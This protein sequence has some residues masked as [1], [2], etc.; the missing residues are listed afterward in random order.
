MQNDGPAYEQLAKE[1]ADRLSA[2]FGMATE[3]CDHKVTLPGRATTNE[4]DVLWVGTIGGERHRVLIECK[5]YGRALEQGKVHLF[6]SVIDDV[7]ADGIPTTGVYVTRAGYQRGAKDIAKTYDVVL[8]ELRTPTDLDLANRVLRIDYEIEM[9]TVSFKGVEFTWDKEPTGVHWPP[10]L[11]D[12][13]LLIPPDGGPPLAVQRL[14]G[15]QR[16]K[17][18]DEQ[19]AE[20]TASPHTCTVRLPTPHP[21]SIDGDVV[22]TA[23]AVSGTPAPSTVRT[24]GS[25]GPGREG[26][27]HILKNTLNGETAWFTVDGKI[28]VMGPL[29]PPES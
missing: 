1:L 12:M 2:A 17:T 13:A 20:A 15:E 23:T 25:M 6:R 19:F 21:V 18:V 4:I 14:L 26:I 7:R 3:R 8:L 11:T 27:V 22:G 9:R 28:R 5:D 10:S 16:G 24:S 29:N